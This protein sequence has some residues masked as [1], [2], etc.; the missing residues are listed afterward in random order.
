M[1]D[2]MMQDVTNPYLE[3]NFAPITEEITATDLQVEGELPKELS[4]RYLRN[5]PNPIDLASRSNHHWFVGSGM[6]HGI[7]LRDGKAEW[8]RNRFVGSK[9][10]SNFRGQPDIAGP[11]WNDSTGGPNT[12]V[13]SFAGKTWAMVEA[14]STPVE[15]TYE[16]ETVGR[17][18]FGGT[19]PGAF[20][21]HPKIDPVTGEMHAM[22]Y[23]WPQWMDH[24]Q[25]VVVGTDGKVRKTVDVPLPGMT[26]MHDMSLT[27]K[28]VVIYDQPVTV[29]FDMLATHSLPFQWNPDYGNRVGLMPREGSANDII[30]IDVPMGYCFHPMNA[31]DNVDGSVTIDL[32][33]YPRMFDR[34]LLGP[35]GDSLSRLERWTLNP[36]TRRI[37]IQVID[38]TPNEFPRHRHDV[39]GQ[40]YR[41]GYCASPSN[42]PGQ[43]W[44]TLKHDLKTGSRALFDHGP[45]MAAGEPV[46]VGKENSD[47]EDAGYLMTFLHDLT[48]ASTEFVVMDAQDFDRGYVA[49]VKLP[50]RIPFGFHGNWSSDASMSPA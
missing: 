12:N 37:N 10:L 36:A 26:M 49:K 9:E 2:Q 39:G 27:E 21:A 47:A 35:F 13:G 41:F 40:P 34:D 20:T 25:Y 31:Y 3:G 19:L 30:W 14:G 29:N 11:N 6:V 32:C 45:G 24:V 46:F 4:G 42:V 1:S 48:N 23:A 17:N 5:G 43:G 15:L 7:R 38:E 28:Y 16:L 50:Q 22:V 33:N 18:D 44:P 8:Y